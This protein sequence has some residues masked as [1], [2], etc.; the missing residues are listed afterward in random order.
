MNILIFTCAGKILRLVRAPLSCPNIEARAAPYRTNVL[1]APRTHL[2]FPCRTSAPLP[3][4]LFSIIFIALPPISFLYCSLIISSKKLSRYLS[5]HFPLY[6][7][8]PIMPLIT[9]ALSVTS[10]LF[11]LSHPSFSSRQA[12]QQSYLTNSYYSR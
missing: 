4:F 8:V 12:G 2:L 6:C 1:Y 11:P 5:S 7:C 10:L 9:C 3:L